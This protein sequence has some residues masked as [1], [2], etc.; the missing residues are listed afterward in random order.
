MS[1]LGQSQSQPYQARLK[2]GQ[3]QQSKHLVMLLI[4]FSSKCLEPVMSPSAELPEAAAGS[5]TWPIEDSSCG[6]S[7]CKALQLPMKGNAT[8]AP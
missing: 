3:L 6:W 4:I 7:T 8:A 5:L 1:S 2:M